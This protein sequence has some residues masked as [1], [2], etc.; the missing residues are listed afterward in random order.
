MTLAVLLPAPVHVKVALFE[1]VVE[2]VV[3]P[4]VL[5]LISPVVLLFNVKL[6]ELVKDTLQEKLVLVI[7]EV[8]D[9]VQVLVPLCVAVFVGVLLPPP[10][11]ISPNEPPFVGELMLGLFQESL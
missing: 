11:G 3:V 6:P 8:D 10:A 1:V 2:P 4:L 9:D 5:A 7:A